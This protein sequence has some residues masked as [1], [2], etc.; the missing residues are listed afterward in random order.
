M[1]SSGRPRC[2]G[3]EE[4]AWASP[5]TTFAPAGRPRLP[6]SV[7]ITWTA[8][9][10]SPLLALPEHVTGVPVGEQARVPAP[11]QTCSL[12]TTATS[13][14]R[15]RQVFGAGLSPIAVEPTVTPSR[16]VPFALEEDDPPPEVLLACA[17]SARTDTAQPPGAGTTQT[18]CACAKLVEVL[19]V[20]VTLPRLSLTE[21]PFV[22]AEVVN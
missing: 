3:C 20:A 5:T 8:R 10:V 11:S 16:L 21:V 1:K 15:V 4:S 17:V 14:S 9:T 6:P 19:V 2:Y 18:F 13:G 7:T 12:R 22:A